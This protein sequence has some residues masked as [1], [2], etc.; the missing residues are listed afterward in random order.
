MSEREASDKRSGASS[1]VLV[2][3][4]GEGGVLSFV[5]RSSGGAVQTIH[6]DRTHALSRIAF[7][8]E[9]TLDRS[10]D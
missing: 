1:D 6:I 2:S 8:R 10:G 4:Y 7:E 9:K 3:G 5:S